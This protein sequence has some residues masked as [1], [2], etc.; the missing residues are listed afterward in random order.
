[1]FDFEKFIM[2][3]W[4]SVSI[5]LK[6]KYFINYGMLILFAGEQTCL[7]A[8]AQ[9]GQILCLLPYRDETKSFAFKT[10]G[11]SIKSRHR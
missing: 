9:S 2:L 3:P 8:Q 11:S 1:M 6:F 5:V 10:E 7:E 4:R